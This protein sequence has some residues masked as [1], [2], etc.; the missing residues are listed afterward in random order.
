MSINHDP[1]AYR[2]RGLAALAASLAL[3][4]AVFTLWPHDLLAP[5]EAAVYDAAAPEVIVLEEIA[6]TVQAP[7]PPPP[8]P[9]LLPPVE[10]PD[11]IEIPDEELD[12]EEPT[13]DLPTE[14]AIPDAPALE[15]T[16][17]P[18][19][20][21]PAFVERPQR[22]P[23]HLTLST[24]TYPEEA[25]R[26]GIRARVRVKVLVNESGQVAEAEVVERLLLRGSEERMVDAIGYGVE[27]AALDAARR[28]RFR[29]ARHDGSR[30]R[31]YTTTTYSFGV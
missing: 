3:V 21:A 19:P 20:A 30:V 25:R 11:E 22:S 14:I 7:P 24:P 9:T 29:P 28:E 10:V 5:A 1:V 15:V 4:C 2:I 26:A 27:A 13:L 17:V 23:V 12:F 31:A 18:A 8:P 16:P 6:Q